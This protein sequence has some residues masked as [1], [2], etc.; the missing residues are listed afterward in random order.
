MA[1]AHTLPMVETRKDFAHR[2]L[3]LSLPIMFQ[4]LLNSSVS[5]VDTMMIG[6]IGADALAAVGLANQV[7]FLITLF[8]F[9][10]SS[11]SSIF[12]AQY[13]GAQDIP[14]MHRTM[15]ISLIVSSAGALFCSFIS[16]AFPTEVMHVFTKDPQVVARG[17]Q[18]LVS[19]GISYL[20]TA[21]VMTFSTAL[22]SIGDT[23]TPLI[24]S[25]IALTINVVLNY[26][27]ING[28]WIFPRLEVVG[29][30]I[31]TVIARF[32]EMVLLLSFVYGKKRPVAASIKTM[33]SFSKAMLRKFFI[34]C[35]PVILN[36]M[37][38]SFGMTTYKIAYA[39][40][41]IDVIAAVNVSESIQGLFF[42]ALMGIGNATA[43]M[44]GNKIGENNIDL[45]KLYAKRC[46]LISFTVGAVLGL[47]LIGTSRWLPI[48]FNLNE[49]L[50]AM[51]MHA[52]IA[53]GAVMSPK[54][55]NMVT[56]VGI[57]RS[58][59]DTRYSLFA[60][61]GGVWLIGVPL[62]FVGG[63]VL[64]FPLWGVYLLVALEEVFKLI[65]SVTRI[66]SGKWIHRLTND[67]IQ[68]ESTRS[69]EK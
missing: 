30:A 40:M 49:S 9:G 10:V 68:L 20:F 47:M 36:E 32:I 16:I 22:R 12:I 6:Q 66:R 38:W 42:V 3:Q 18:Y 43:I 69:L 25:S 15:G 34:T 41:G 7:F 17:V 55:V 67:H 4:N 54:A 60:E 44:I 28:I 48:P 23:K 65:I 29:A 62:A 11:G 31:A 14:S 19:V 46:I 35:T 27:L 21:I 64:G 33:F 24:A 52:L 5:F 59:G 58:G 61:M 1:S 2:L 26:L 56:I 63:L 51:T 37:F 45:A 57:L 53:L 39:R 8:F 50:H 13:W